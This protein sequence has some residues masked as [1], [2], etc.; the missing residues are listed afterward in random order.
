[1]PNGAGGQNHMC[2]KSICLSNSASISA[3]KSQCIRL[4]SKQQTSAWKSR[5]WQFLT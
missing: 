3:Y 4:P 1:M 2:I 5:E